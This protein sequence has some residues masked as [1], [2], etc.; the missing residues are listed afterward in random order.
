MAVW[1]WALSAGRKGGQNSQPA[2]SPLPAPFWPGVR[3]VE[4]A[5]KNPPLWGG[6]MAGLGG[7][8]TSEWG[9]GLGDSRCNHRLLQ[10]RGTWRLSIVSSSFY[11]DGPGGHCHSPPWLDLPR[12]EPCWSPTPPSS[13][14]KP[15][16]Y[17]K[18]ELRS[19]EEGQLGSPGQAGRDLPAPSRPS[20][21]TSA[22]LW[23]PLLQVWD[24]LCNIDLHNSPPHLRARVKV[25]NGDSETAAQRQTAST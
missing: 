11:R 22:C 9:L 5:Q 19:S 14:L 20:R 1:Q 12:V 17:P 7:A 10:L 23:R 8:E 3:P 6:Q 24:H 16:E 2:P 15:R 13:L 25:L 4:R 21:P 18:Q